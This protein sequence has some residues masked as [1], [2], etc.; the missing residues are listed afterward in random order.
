MLLNSF[1]LDWH[2]KNNELFTTWLHEK[3][4]T[5]SEFFK[6]IKMSVNVLAK[7]TET[8]WRFLPAWLTFEKQMS[9]SLHILVTLFFIFWL[10]RTT[11][12][13]FSVCLLTHFAR[14]DRQN[15]NLKNKQNHAT[16]VTKTHKKTKLQKLNEF[17]KKEF[18][19]NLDKIYLDKIKIKSG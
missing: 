19:K 7:R 4:K 18:F 12:I 3:G 6:T 16:K 8:N 17:N 10:S 14:Q 13:I 2:L 11:K 1:R 5:N 15:R 9:G